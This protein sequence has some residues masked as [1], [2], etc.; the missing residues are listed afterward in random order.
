M[1]SSNPSIEILKDLTV[2]VIDDTLE[3][4]NIIK[5][6][7]MDMGVTQVFTARDGMEALG[8]LG[9]FGDGE[10]DVILCDWKMP[11]LSGL[12]VLKQVR[13]CDRDVA[14]VMITGVADHES[15][16]EAKTHGITGYIKKPFSAD[17]LEKK[18]FAI[19]RIVA[20]RKG[21]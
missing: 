16:M 14:F 17:Q 19:S 10:V 6:M 21:Q 7:L 3:A 12:E 1:Q 11:R 4:L 2:L 9:A 20:H 13:T 15:V 5:V 8:F 18:M